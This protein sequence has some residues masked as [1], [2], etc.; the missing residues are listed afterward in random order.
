MLK[1]IMLKNILKIL[2]VL[3]LFSLFSHSTLANKKK[4][5]DVEKFVKQIAEFNN[6]QADF[7][8][9]VNNESG[10]EIDVTS[11][12]F[13]IQRPNYFRW[14][15]KKEFEQLIV[16]D[17]KDIFTYDIDLDQV[18]I[19]TQS[20]LLA[21]SPLLLMTS[22]AKTIEKSF[23]VT[24]IDLS[25]NQKALFQLKPKDQEGV[26]E[27][28]NI[29]FQKNQLT[30]LMMIDSLGQQTSVTFSN[31]KTNTEF[32]SNLFSFVMPEGIDIVDSRETSISTE[33]E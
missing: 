5:T 21:N 27:L 29:L 25:D 12:Q 9:R 3:I 31:I 6:Y 20:E 26:F 32:E 7:E 33:V 2:T 18:T 30:E 19:Q 17:G 23:D 14:E 16:A 1:T 11:G 10:K 28:V 4:Q 13:S 22:D 15:T 8:Q 24:K